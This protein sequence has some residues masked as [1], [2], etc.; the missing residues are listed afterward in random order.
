MVSLGYSP[1]IRALLEDVL[2]HWSSL[3]EYRP[4]MELGKD[5]LQTGTTPMPMV[6]ATRT[7]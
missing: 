1:S 6:E 4:D 7:E 2:H 5:L 3:S